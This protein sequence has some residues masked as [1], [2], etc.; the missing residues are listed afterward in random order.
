VRRGRLKTN[1][2]IREGSNVVQKWPGI[3]LP[4][5]LTQCAFESCRNTSGGRLRGHADLWFKKLAWS[6]KS[7]LR[8]PKRARG[9][10]ESVAAFSDDRHR[11]R[12]RWNAH[13][14]RCWSD[15]H[16]RHPRD[17]CRWKTSAERS[18]SAKSQSCH[19]Y[20]GRSSCD[21]RRYNSAGWNWSKVRSRSGRYC[22]KKTAGSWNSASFHSSSS[23]CC[24]HWADDPNGS[25]PQWCS[26]DDLSCRSLAARARSRSCYLARSSCVRYCPT[27]LRR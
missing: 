15:S 13:R 7:P 14:H 27:C 19:S 4:L 16:L 20:A 8:G 18:R 2:G 21:C 25:F 12:H 6:K 26:T 23:A 24:L 5:D 11:G 22:T 17:S 9:D 3:R 10:V 1:L